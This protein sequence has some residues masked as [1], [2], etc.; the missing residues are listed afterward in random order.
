M[1]IRKD[2]MIQAEVLLYFLYIIKTPVEMDVRL[3]LV[4]NK[5]FNER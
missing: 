4:E 1:I 2:M 5:E 3:M